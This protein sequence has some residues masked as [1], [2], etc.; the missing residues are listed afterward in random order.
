MT[1]ARDCHVYETLIDCIKSRDLNSV[2]KLIDSIPGKLQ[3]IKSFPPSLP[4]PICTAAEIGDDAIF[5]FLLL[6]GFDPDRFASNDER[7]NVIRLKPIH[8]AACQGNVNIVRRLVDYHG[9]SINSP[10]SKGKTPLL[11]AV[12]R[13]SKDVAR[14]LISR[15]A[16]VNQADTSGLTP[17]YMSVGKFHSLETFKL[18]IKSGGDVNVKVRSRCLFYKAAVIGRLDKARILYDHGIHFSEVCADLWMRINI[19]LIKLLIEINLPL[20]YPNDKETS[21]LEMGLERTTPS[22]STQAWLQLL[23]SAGHPVT[24]A[25]VDIVSDRFTGDT[26]DSIQRHL[27]YYV[28]NPRTLQALCCFNIREILG[29]RLLQEADYLPLPPGLMRF[30]RLENLY[31]TL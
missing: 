23:V 13:H 20:V 26:A 11:W 16:D 29:V 30:V 22:E 4:D 15:G 8:I 7:G 27:Q 10:D 12:H 24:Q 18:L 1:A 21:P 3:A 31:K 5:N 9:V 2:Q 6:S 25:A 14:Y 17:L 28:S 19:S